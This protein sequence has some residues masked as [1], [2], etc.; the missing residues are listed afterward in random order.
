M[1]AVLMVFSSFAFIDSGTSVSYKGISPN[2]LYSV[3]IV[4]VNN[5][6]NATPTPFDEEIVVNSSYYAPY[7]NANLSNVFFSFSNGTIIPSWLQ[8]G[9][10][11]TL[12]NSTYWLRLNQSIAPQSQI[13]VYMSF[14]PL[15]NIAFNGVSTG[16]APELTSIYGYYDNGANVF[17]LYSNFSGTSLNG[18]I[19]N[20]GSSCNYVVDNGISFMPNVTSSQIVSNQKFSAPSTVQAF[21]VMANQTQFNSTSCFLGGVGFGNSAIVGTAPVMTSG[22]AENSTNWL[23]LSVWDNGVCGVPNG[24]NAYG[25]SRSLNPNDSY[26]YGVTFLNGSSTLGSINN[27]V[28]NKSH[29]ILYSSPTDLN[30]VMGFQSGNYPKLNHFYWVF[31]RNSTTNGYNLPYSFNG[32]TYNVKIVSHGLHLTDK[33]VISIKN[34]SQY[35]V[36]SSGL[37]LQLVNGTYYYTVSSLNTNYTPT[38]HSGQFNVSGT[39]KTVTIDFNPVTFPVT[40]D[41]VGLAHGTPWQATAG[42]NSNI[43]SGSST[44]LYLMNGSYNITISDSAGYQANPGVINVLVSGSSQSFEVAFTSPTN[45]SFIRSL[46]TLYMLSNFTHSGNYLMG[47]LIIGGIP[48]IGMVVDQTNNRLYYLSSSEDAISIYN[49]TTGSYLPIFKLH[50]IKQLP[51]SLYYSQSSDLLFLYS[52]G[53]G[54]F[55]TVSVFNPNNMNLVNE[56]RLPTLF[57]YNFAKFSA[58]NSNSSLIFL[59]EFNSSSYIPT[60]ATITASGT[61]IH[62]TNFS[63]FPTSSL[64]TIL[65]S[66][67][68]YKDELL[69]TNTTSLDIIN[70]SSGESTFINAP[71]GDELLLPVEIG[72]SP[73]FFLGDTRAGITVMFNLSAGA[74]YN[75]TAYSF[76]AVSS[77]YDTLNGVEYVSVLIPSEYFGGIVALNTSTGKVLS[78]ILLPLSEISIALQMSQTNQSLLSLSN[79]ANA[80]STNGQVLIF[81]VQKAYNVTFSESG[82]P[83]RTDWFVNISGKLSSG[84]INSGSTYSLNMV[85][86]TYSYSASTTDKEFRPVYTNTFAVSGSSLSVNVS[87][88]PV[89]YA[90]TFSESGLPA[91]VPWYVNVSGETTSGAILSTTFSESLQNGSYVFATTTSDLNYA[92]HYT[93]TFTVSGSNLSINITFNQIRFAVTFTETGLPAG[94]SWNI[95]V[96]GVNHVVAGTSLTIYFLNGTYSY[97]AK[98]A[99][100]TTVNGTGN[101][102]VSGNQVSISISF[103]P[104][105]SSPGIDLIDYIAIGVVIAVIV[106]A[107]L[108]LYLRKKK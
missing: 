52:I 54:N 107:G 72:N 61:L 75:D 106:V 26:V 19:W 41:E 45:L 81:G 5:G 51:F 93:S 20:I 39:S 57:E 101:I 89:V 77:A 13:T 7:E 63:K 95:T 29:V 3:P 24:I 99:G 30:V 66:L 36:S 67:Q 82:L 56:I 76:V 84:P 55:S 18:L 71:A 15:G 103:K 62:T 1:F 8:S 32:D 49:L 102:T 31:E 68:S 22:W 97:S 48:T 14:F 90:V 91:N 79:V 34:L 2:V 92:A 33:F 40:L 74:F 80:S 104:I 87:Y 25:Y 83:S 23:G 28:M 105:T 6:T 100:Y 43:S 98:L 4:I 46:N 47:N 69:L 44:S 70:V 86:G 96:D 65:F 35:T 78:E 16:E 12:S 9:N 53:T 73:V 64:T 50:E 85:N 27:V 58:D 10:S 60:V 37:S 17:N 21:G 59:T 88:K 108:V 42:N 94:T 11:N 38:D